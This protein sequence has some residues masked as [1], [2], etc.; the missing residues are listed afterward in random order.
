[1]GR[2]SR[3]LRSSVP[4][5]RRPG[6]LLARECL[7]LSSPLEELATEGL[8]GAVRGRLL[9]LRTGRSLGLG[10]AGE[11]R[12]RPIYLS[13]MGVEG[14]L[15]RSPSTCPVRRSLGKMAEG[16]VEVNRLRACTFIVLSNLTNR[17]WLV[18]H[19]RTPPTFGTTDGQERELSTFPNR[20]RPV[21]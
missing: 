11:E 8:M 15:A 10:V 5:E 6:G 16:L 13:K 17:L 2:Q 9:F 7:C 19:P 21:L 18:K 20:D 14:T 1:M 3:L 12:V 4:V